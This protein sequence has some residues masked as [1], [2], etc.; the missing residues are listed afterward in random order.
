[1]DFVERATE[2]YL[3]SL[4]IGEVR[5]CPLGE[6]TFPDFSVDSRIGVECT[7]LVHLIEK[8]GTKYN[9]DE[10]QPRIIQSLENAFKLLQFHNLEH[11]YLICLDFDIDLDVRAA[12]KQLKAYLSDLSRSSAIVNH[13][14]IITDGLEIEI[15]R[16]SN[17]YEAPFVL[18]AMTCHDNAAWVLEQLAAQTRAAV[19]RKSTKL[20]SSKGRFDEWWLAVSGSLAVGLSESYADFVKAE[21]RGSLLWD[22]VLLVDPHD[23]RKSRVIEIKGL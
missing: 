14:Q 16:A 19:S 2:Q 22:K 7:R 5:H 11:S 8:N 4:N 10:L 21:L 6:G 18:G 12:Q 15:F 13:R 1:M 20:E 23:P 17:L 9:L 3:L